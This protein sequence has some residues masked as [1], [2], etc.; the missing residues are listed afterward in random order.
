MLVAQ[1]TRACP[2]RA[3]SLAVRT[4]WARNALSEASDALAAARD[5]PGLMAALVEQLPRLQIPGAQVALFE[6]RRPESGARL[7]LSVRGGVVAPVTDALYPS[8]RL[9]PEGTLPPEQRQDLIVLPLFARAEPLGIALLELGPREPTIYEM[10][11]D[12]LERD[13]RPLTR[14]ACPLAHSAA[15]RSEGGERLLLGREGAG[16]VAKRE[17]RE[18]TT[19]KRAMHERDPS[20]R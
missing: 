8:A 12:R 15:T 1:A 17:V 16:V 13:A 9:V 18:T 20:R 6:A 14:S 10:L 7:A 5:V 19:S 4:R 2:S 11:R 3:R